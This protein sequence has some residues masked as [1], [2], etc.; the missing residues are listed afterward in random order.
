MLASRLDGASVGRFMGLGERKVARVE[1]LSSLGPA[2]RQLAGE[3][4]VLGMGLWLD[5]CSW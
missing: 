2:E 5:T 4:I 3:V 1:V